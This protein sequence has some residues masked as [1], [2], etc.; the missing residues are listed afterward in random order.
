M[1]SRSIFDR[2]DSP[3]SK[4]KHAGSKS[5]TDKRVQRRRRREKMAKRSR[6]INRRNP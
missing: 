4:S 2:F 3:F 6:K 1:A 5:P